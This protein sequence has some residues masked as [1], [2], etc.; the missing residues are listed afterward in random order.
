MKDST[1]TSHKKIKFLIAGALNTGFGLLTAALFFF[2]FSDKINIYLILC[3]V[4]IFNIT[5][6]FL[7][8]KYYVF[9]S[10]GKFLTEYLRSYITYG[11][12]FIV[13]LLLI[14]FFS[15]LF[16]NFYYSLLVVTFITVVISYIGHNSLTFKEEKNE[17]R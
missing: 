15:D 8:H 10:S 17:H 7:N 1:L 5:F 16:G 2:I 6:A 11:F 9:K 4:N 13:S 12:S 3:I 14:P